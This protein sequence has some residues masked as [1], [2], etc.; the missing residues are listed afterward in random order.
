MYGVRKDLY[1]N[2]QAEIRNSIETK[3]ALFNEEPLAVYG[4]KVNNILYKK[5]KRIKLK[6]CSL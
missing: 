6:M 2:M 5:S 4:E 3:K 1:K